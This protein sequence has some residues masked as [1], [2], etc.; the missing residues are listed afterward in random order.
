MTTSVAGRIVVDGWPA[1][2]PQ[3]VRRHYEEIH[4][5]YD[6]EGWMRGRVIMEAF[7]GDSREQAD[8]EREHRGGPRPDFV[9][10]GE[11]ASFA[12][13]LDPSGRLAWNSN[14]IAGDHAVAILSERVS[15][16]YLSILQERGV[17][18]VLAGPQDVNLRLARE[19]IASRFGVKTLLLEGGGGINRSL[20]LADGFVWLRYRIAG[21]H[22]RSTEDKT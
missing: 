15:D 20:R 14:D 18:Y 3:A 10:P 8:V 12:F 22:A 2:V 1:T 21:Q 13:A 5:R 17:S 16:D 6:A 19:K 11:H 7:A 4:E 9:A